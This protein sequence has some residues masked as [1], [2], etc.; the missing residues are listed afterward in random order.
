M[1]TGNFDSAGACMEGG[2]KGVIYKS[3]LS[4]TWRERRTLGLEVII[5]RW[6]REDACE[7]SPLLPSTEAQT[8][9]RTKRTSRQADLLSQ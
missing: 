9:E 3:V 8:I 7:R 4:P 5:A 6:M 2:I 1:I